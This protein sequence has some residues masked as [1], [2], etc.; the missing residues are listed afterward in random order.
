M[1]LFNHILFAQ[2]CMFGKF[3]ILKLKKNKTQ[4]EQ[5]Q[6]KAWRISSPKYAIAYEISRIMFLFN[7]ILFAQMCKKK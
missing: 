4:V 1:F 6:R 5:G 7:H 3:M 2:M